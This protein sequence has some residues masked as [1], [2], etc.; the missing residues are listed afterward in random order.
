MKLS[1][2]LVKVDKSQIFGLSKLAIV[3]LLRRGRNEAH[4]RVAQLRTTSEQ[5]NRARRWLEESKSA[6]K[7]S[8]SVERI[9]ANSNATQTES[10]LLKLKLKRSQKEIEKLRLE[11]ELYNEE[12]R[13]LRKTVERMSNGTTVE[14]IARIAYVTMVKNSER[15]IYYNLNYHKN[16][17]INDFFI[18]DN[19]STDCTRELIRQFQSENPDARVI[20]LEDPTIG[21]YQSIRMTA[22]A[23]LAFDYGCNWILPID[24]DELLCSSQGPLNLPSFL[25][26]SIDPETDPATI[27]I[28]RCEYVA[29]DSDD[30]S[31]KNPFLRLRHRE[32]SPSK[33]NQTV[34]VRWKKGLSLAQGN[35]RVTGNTN[36][37]L[38]VGNPLYIA[39][40]PYLDVQH[41][42]EKIIQ[43]GIAYEAATNLYPTMGMHWKLFYNRYQR[44]GDE[45][46]VDVLNEFNASKKALVEL[47][48]HAV[49]F[50]PN[51]R[52]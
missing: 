31:E 47:P 38:S 12:N 49:M 10:E 8:R 32:T 39:H 26:D 29:C 17:G 50:K 21:Y 5:W 9:A 30:Q 4:A 37:L 27:Y 19:G 46:F 35:H 34:L 14:T 52:S 13:L 15:F 33:P 40:F 16:I 6:N 20:V 11:R 22:L 2:T 41:I 23:A 51:S 48:L 28:P 36:R 18:C 24:D 45:V 1:Q 42:K 25:L 7:C 44:Y 43:G 3:V